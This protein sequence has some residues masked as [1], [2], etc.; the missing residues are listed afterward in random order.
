MIGERIKKYREEKGLS[1]TGLSEILK[2]S[3]SALSQLEGGRTR[4]SA[5]TILAFSEKTD[6]NLKYLLEGKEPILD[7]LGPVGMA[8]ERAVSKITVAE[9]V[10]YIDIGI[11]D[12]IGAGNLA[13]FFGDPPI[14]LAKVPKDI[15]NGGMFYFEVVGDSMF[16]AIR[17][18]ALVGVD[19]RNKK[20]FSGEIYAVWFHP[21]GAAL[22]YIQ[23]T[24]KTVVF[25]S[26]NREAYRDIEI[27]TEELLDEHSAVQI[28]GK[29][30]FLQQIY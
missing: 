12:Q 29:L 5:E 15:H 1:V 30:K 17:R 23:T 20:L 26:A 25:Y 11:H 21:E 27:A 9:E 28:V 14:K 22:K 7:P 6:I 16:P 13:D 24:G 2:I 18:G 19:T 10:E 3:H 8:I 4:P